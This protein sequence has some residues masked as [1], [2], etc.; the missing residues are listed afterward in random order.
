MIKLIYNSEIEPGEMRF[1]NECVCDSRVLIIAPAPKN[2]DYANKF[3]LSPF[4]GARY[5]IHKGL[6][7]IV[8][9]YLL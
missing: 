1:D 9:P 4:I 5:E 2:S 7:L 6:S 8:R 3:P